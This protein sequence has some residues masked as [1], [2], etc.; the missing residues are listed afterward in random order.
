MKK[1]LVVLLVLGFSAAP[2][3]AVQ[4]DFGASVRTHA[5]YYDVD[6]EYAKG[7]YLDGSIGNDW[8]DDTGFLMGLDGNS[9]FTAKAMVSEK[10]YGVVQLGLRDA[11]RADGNNDDDYLR[12]AYGVW[13]FGAGKLLM[14]K[15]YTP[16]TY[17]GY[18]KMSADIGDSGNGNMLLAGLPYIGRQPQIKLM[19]G[20][21]DIAFIEQHKD[22]D[23]F[24]T[25][26]A[27]EGIANT[28]TDFS[29]P[30]IEA[31]YVFRTDLVN[32]R[33]VVGFQTYEL[34][35]DG[36]GSEDIDSYL[37]GIGASFDLKPFYVKATAS[38]MQ[39]AANYGKGTLGTVTY[40]GAALDQ[41]GDL[42]DSDLYQGTLVA[43]M[44]VNKM[45]NIEAGFGY[46]NAQL[47]NSTV[48]VSEDFGLAN[49]LYLGTKDS[50][51]EAYIYYLQAWISLSKNVHII[52]EIG[53]I[54]RNDA[55]YE[56]TPEAI[57]TAA[58]AGAALPGGTQKS[59]LGK[60]TYGNIC[61]RL[62]F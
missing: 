42:E 52:P 26:L 61:F 13:N 24:S 4:W 37:V 14:G 25:R 19:F 33:P 58:A 12:M 44:K 7:P 36:G 28:D 39:N 3:M 48:D 34:E 27:A 62:E 47:D 41:D 50:E 55:E 57:A 2:A 1:L 56:W 8:D 20:D 23:D 31:A 54:D 32:I 17:L 16:G 43:G 22:A 51:Q 38:Y 60:M 9:T 5:G 30:R 18:S 45:L 21:L 10:F 59:D 35:A 29:L 49:P 53:M 40:T 6:Q 46:Q 15:D 11:T